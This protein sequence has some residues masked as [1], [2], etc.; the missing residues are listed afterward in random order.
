MIKIFHSLLG[1]SQDGHKPFE[2]I[3]TAEESVEALRL[4]HA[5]YLTIAPVVDI[6]DMLAELLAI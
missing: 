5:Q 6:P 4:T 1:F 3:G 2:C